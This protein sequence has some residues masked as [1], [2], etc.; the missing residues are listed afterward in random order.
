M[1]SDNRIEIST[2]AVDNA[3]AALSTKELKSGLR[4]AFRR[5]L[6]PIRKAAVSNYK[7]A[8]PGSQKWKGIFL[9][10][11]R[12]S[13]GGSVAIVPRK[14]VKGS[15]QEAIRKEVRAFVLVFLERGTQP[16]KTDKGYNRGIMPKK[17]FFVPAKAAMPNVSQT[18]AEELKKEF[19]K[20]MNNQ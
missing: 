18:F 3:I 4:A 5:C 8:F 12:D 2:A 1:S 11:D 15:R 16:R 14:R 13:L 7:A 19:G 10:Y 9:S 20:R 6:S 17:P